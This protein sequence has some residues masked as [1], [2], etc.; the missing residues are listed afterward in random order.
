MAASLDPSDGE[1]GFQ[2]APMVDVVFVLML[3]FLACAGWQV[4]ERE[5]QANL[6]RNNG[7]STI[8]EPIVIDIS[9]D[10]EVKANGQALGADTDRPLTS[11]RTWF[12]EVL[13]FGSQPP[14]FIRP[15]PAT[16]HERIMD[17]LNACKAVGIK[18]V[19]F[20]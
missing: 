8:V 13:S 19:T 1:I 5:L 17:V 2:I 7:G 12:K 11:L 20:S 18:D 3:F 10:G 15:A 4:K 16:R 6:P 9:A 14:V